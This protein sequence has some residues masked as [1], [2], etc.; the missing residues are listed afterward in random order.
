MG[1]M[2]LAT[3]RRRVLSAVAVADASSFV[4]WPSVNFWAMH[5]RDG[6]RRRV[7]RCPSALRVCRVPRAV[8]WS[9]VWT[10]PIRWQAGESSLL[11]QSCLRLS[12]PPM[13]QA[14]LASCLPSRANPVSVLTLPDGA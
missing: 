14:A 2:M 11:R 7:G 8:R 13:G 6:Q 9:Y 12:R 5:S 1:M 3:Y 4:D 10:R